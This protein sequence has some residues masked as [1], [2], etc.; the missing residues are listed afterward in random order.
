[1]QMRELQHSDAAVRVKALR[2]CIELLQSPKPCVRCLMAG[3]CE[4]LCSLLEVRSA[5]A[6]LH[7]TQHRTTCNLISKHQRVK[8][9]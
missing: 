3:V 7:M 4:P 1:M 2:A 6:K 9:A 5:F 8:A